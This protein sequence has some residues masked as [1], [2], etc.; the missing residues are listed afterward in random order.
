MH[1]S[2]H[3]VLQIAREHNQKVN[4]ITV[5]NELGIHVK[6]REKYSRMVSLCV[7]A[8]RHLCSI[9]SHMKRIDLV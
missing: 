9:M 5:S 1:S 6:V 8:V 3:R 2:Y 4:W 7:G